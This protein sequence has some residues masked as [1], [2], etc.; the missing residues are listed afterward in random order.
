MR[1]ASSHVCLTPSYIS[2]RTVVSCEATVTAFEAQ[3]DKAYVA[4]F[5]VSKANADA[6]AVKAPMYFQQII[7]ENGD[8][9]WRG[10]QK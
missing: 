6:N 2:R 1:G 10:N 8:W 7:K 4:G 5:Y 9:K 3:G